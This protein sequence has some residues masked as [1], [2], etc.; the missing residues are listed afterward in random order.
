LSNSSDIQSA[1]Q[2]KRHAVC[3]DGRPHTGR[4]HHREALADNALRPSGFAGDAC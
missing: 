3:A 4:S 1:M 2:T